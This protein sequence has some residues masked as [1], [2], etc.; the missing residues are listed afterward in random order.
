MRYVTWRMIRIATN[1][2]RIG[3]RHLCDFDLIQPYSLPSKCGNNASFIGRARIVMIYKKN[4]LGFSL[5]KSRVIDENVKC[6]SFSISYIVP[7]TF[8]IVW[9]FDLDLLFEKNGNVKI[10]TLH[11]L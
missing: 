2:A 6:S 11:Q 7:R 3:V 9:H 5:I 8:L 4:S 1:D 10:Q